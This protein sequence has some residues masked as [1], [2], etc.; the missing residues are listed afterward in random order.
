[1]I[2]SSVRI[3]CAETIEELRRPSRKTISH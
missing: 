2:V 3:Q 1:M